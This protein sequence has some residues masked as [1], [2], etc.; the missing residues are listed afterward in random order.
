MLVGYAR[1]STTDQNLALQR[2]ALKA[3]GV[4]ECF[5]RSRYWITLLTYGTVLGGQLAEKYLG[6]PEPTRRALNTGRYRN[7]GT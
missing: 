4:Q 1:V 7:T 2:D 6:Q 5:H 3:A